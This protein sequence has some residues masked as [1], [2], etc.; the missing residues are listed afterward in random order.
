MEAARTYINRFSDY[1]GQPANAYRV[2]AIGR[3]EGRAWDLMKVRFKGGAIMWTMREYDQDDPQWSGSDAYFSSIQ[4][5]LDSVRDRLMGT[6]L[7]NPIGAPKA[8]GFL[9]YGCEDGAVGYSR[10]GWN[11]TYTSKGEWRVSAGYTTSDLRVQS[12]QFDDIDE[13]IEYFKFESPHA[14]KDAD[15]AGFGIKCVPALIES[16]TWVGTPD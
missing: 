15:G 11:I 4:P 8:G 14:F 9:H 13:A 1:K 5:T 6:Q 3:R 10:R 12:P 2:I 7:K 16:T